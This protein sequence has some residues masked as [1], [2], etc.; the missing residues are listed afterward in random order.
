MYESRINIKY[1]TSNAVYILLF[2][3]KSVLMCTCTFTVP[4]FSSLESP[5]FHSRVYHLGR[6]AHVWCIMYM[7]VAVSVTLNSQCLDPP[8]GPVV[9]KCGRYFC[10]V[11]VVLF[12]YSL[13]SLLKIIIYKTKKL[14]LSALLYLYL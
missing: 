1:I 14:S 5:G 12:I 8:E 13:I 7:G 11:V 6:D 4:K 10:F 2:K 9:L 3:R